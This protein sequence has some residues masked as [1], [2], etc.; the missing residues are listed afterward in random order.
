MR[1]SRR[2]L[3]VIGETAKRENLL[4]E[5]IEDTTAP[6]VCFGRVP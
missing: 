6:K 3:G 5:F 1:E 4:R 2:D